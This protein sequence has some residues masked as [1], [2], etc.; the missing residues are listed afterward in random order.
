M[1]NIISVIVPVYFNEKSLPD[2]FEQLKM[3]ENKLLEKELGLEL[4]FVDDGS[5]DGS[6]AHL[7]E[8]KLRRPDTIVIK[9][10]RNFGAI[11]AIKTGLK[12]VTG[13][14]F[15][16]L[17]ADLQDPPELILEMADHWLSGSK[18]VIC[19][20]NTRSDPLAKKI[21]ANLYYKVLR[22]LVLKNYPKGGYDLSLMD[23]TFLPHLLNSSKSVFLPLLAYWMGYKP[24]TIY[25][26]RRP[27]KH[28]RSQWTLAKN[29]IAFFDI[30]LG[31]SITPIRLVS[32]IGLIVALASFFYGSIVVISSFFFQIPVKGFVTIVALITFL[33]GLIL[34]MLGLI[35]EYLWRI[36]SELDK[37]PDTVIEEI[38]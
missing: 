32:G 28:G 30:I 17:A 25:Y 27:R 13:G 6:L 8:F 20:R 37:R 7:L 18:F 16:F 31:F 34:V 36:F 22:T 4:I 5:G 19:A 23:K 29:L 12:F 9:L 10:T 35:G 21:F 33:L 15:S 2:L 11:K 3:V 38:F 26:H 1:K 24:E 14:A